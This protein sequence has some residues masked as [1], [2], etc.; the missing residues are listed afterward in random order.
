MGMLSNCIFHWD[1]ED[2][3]L[4]IKSKRKELATQHLILKTDAEV[5]KHLS[6]HEL[7]LHCRRKTRGVVETKKLI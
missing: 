6:R 7:A 3:S 5:I 2:L 1:E 4:L